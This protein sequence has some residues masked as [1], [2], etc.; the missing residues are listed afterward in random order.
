[1]DSPFVYDRRVTG[2][3]YVGRRKE[4]R[5]MANML[6]G[7]EN[8]VI[9]GPPKSGKLSTVQQALFNMKMGGER[10]S[11]CYVNLFN[12]RSVEE[13]LLRMGSAVMRSQVSTP[14]EFQNIVRTHLANTHF[15]FDK[16]RYSE[17]DEVLSMNWDADAN[18]IFC[19]LRLPGRIAASRGERIYMVVEEFQTIAQLDGGDRVLRSLKDALSERRLDG[20]GCTFILTGS[21]YNAMD[22]IFGRSPMFRGVVE[23]FNVPAPEDAEIADYI[24]KGLLVTGKVIEKDLAM[25]VAKMFDCNMWYISHFMAICESLTKGYITNA[26]LMDALK[27]LISVHEPRFTSAMSGLT[28]FQI[29]FLQAVVDGITRFTSAEVIRKYKLNSSANVVRIREALMKKEIITFNDKDEPVFLDP[30]F[31][32][33][34]EKT[35][36]EMK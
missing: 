9:Y 31:R 25:S 30:L 16:Y 26:V 17:A 34:V 27:V 1:M 19:L 36:F 35:Y 6:S 8:I 4:C 12:V 29:S 3:N 21:R 7:G 22:A 10:F 28:W 15:V 23:R 20:C 5:I 33:W 32:Y 14:D 18:D 13:F 24:T 11:T 2:K